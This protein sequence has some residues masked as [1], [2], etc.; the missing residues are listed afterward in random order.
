MAPPKLQLELQPKQQ[1]STPA[2]DEQAGQLVSLVAS[3]VPRLKHERHPLLST[4]DYHGLV[5]RC[6]QLE[7]RVF[8]KAEAMDLCKELRKPNQYLFVVLQI[9]DPGMLLLSYGVLAPSKVDCVARITKVCTDPLYRGLGAGEHLVRSMLAAL[10]HSALDSALHPSATGRFASICG[11]GGL[12]TDI[13]DI[14]LHVDTRRD[15]AVRMYTRCGFSTKTTIPNYYAEGRD[16]LL[17]STS[18]TMT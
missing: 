3:P 11:V 13:R 2:L 8:P 12:R 1:Y 18:T 16:A 17:M 15:A 5:A 14:Q 4:S 7:R 10:G 6:Q 9:N